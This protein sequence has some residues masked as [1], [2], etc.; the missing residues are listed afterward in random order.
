MLEGVS[1]SL[2]ET[3]LSSRALDYL[4]AGPSD[5]VALI[6]H[7]CQLPGAPR[8]VAEQMAIA[9]FAGRTE[10]ARDEA[11]RWWLAAQLREARAAAGMGAPG[12]AGGGRGGG[13]ARGG[14]EGAGAAAPLGGPGAPRDELAELSYVVVDVE[15]TGMRAWDGDRITEIA[16][17]VV[18]DG[19]VAE[20]FQ[21]LVNPERP[22]PPMITALTH[23]SW[24]MVKDAPR[25]RD[26][27]DDV[28]RMLGGHV[29]VAHNA[30]FDWRFV[31]AEIARAAG[32][33]LL[34][35]RLCTVRLARRLLP[36]LRSRKLDSLAHYYNV[37]IAARHR[38]AGDAVAT[39]QILLRLLDGARERDCRTWADLQRLVGTR[40]VFGRPRR[41]SA[42]P[43]PIDK[44]TTA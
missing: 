37:E 11:G 4:A 27:C 25:F 21:T 14:G 18:R 20:V 41:R 3:L 42:L 43:R 6:E 36:H 31:S 22:I 5:A 19:E 28:L 8:V 17:V 12:G 10:F 16:A 33:E 2:T 1:S 32:R 15:T 9:L 26:I 39:A 7:V 13:G 29:F 23:I 30:D 34:G 35:P 44:D 24:E 38:A 40:G